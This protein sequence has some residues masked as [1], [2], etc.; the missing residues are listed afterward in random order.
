M[1]NGKASA[2]LFYLRSYEEKVLSGAETTAESFDGYF[3]PNLSLA[4]STKGLFRLAG[5]LLL[6]SI[7]SVVSLAVQRNLDTWCQT[8]TTQFTAVLMKYVT[9]KHDKS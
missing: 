1:G 4:T 9:R 2:V 6:V 7:A 3:G 8:T 5:D